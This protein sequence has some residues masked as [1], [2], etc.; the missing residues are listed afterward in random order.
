M[1]VTGLRSNG[2]TCFQGHAR[3]RGHDNFEQCAVAAR[4]RCFQIAIEQ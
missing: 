2:K 4:E 1:A 3:V